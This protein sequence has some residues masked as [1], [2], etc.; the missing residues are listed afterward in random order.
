MP[1][2][3]VAVDTTLDENPPKSTK[4]SADDVLVE[5]A[6]KGD[7][8]AVRAGLEK[9]S[10]DTGSKTVVFDAVHEACRGNHD[11]CLA[12]L[13][14]YVETT[15]M[16]FGNLLS[17]CV[18]ADHVAC[19][20]VLL[21]HWKSVCSNVAMVP[22]GQEDTEGRACPA[23]WA[24]PAVCQVLIDAGADIDIYDDMGRSPLHWAC[25]SGAHAVAKILVTAGAEVCGTCNFGST[26]LIGA[27]YYGHTE[28]VRY[29]VGLKGLHDVKVNH[30]RDNLSALF[31]AVRQ[32]HTAVV[33]LLIDAGAD[34]ETTNKRLCTPLLYAC[35]KGSQP[36]V[37]MLVEAGAEVRCA[38]QDGHPCL[39]IA[40][41][42]GHIE[43]VRY[44]VGVP[45]VD[46]SHK[47]EGGYTALLAAAENC[48]KRA[49]VVEVLIDAGSDIE[50]KLGE[51]DGRSPLLVA[52]ECGNL[53]AVEVLVR[54]GADV[55]VTDNEGES[56][57]TLA[58][59]YGHTE[60]VRTLLC[61]PEVDMS[62]SNNS[63]NTSLHHAVLK[64]YSGVVQLLIDAGADV[65]ANNSWGSRPLHWA[66]EVG[67]LEIVEMLVKA[68]AD[69]C[70]VDDNSTT[71]LIV[72]ALHGRTETV[73]YL[74]GLNVDVNHRDLSGLTALHHA[75][76]KQHADVVQVLLKHGA[77]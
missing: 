43:T 57:L 11:E 53:R 1:K 71:C 65:K 8:T 73:R 66:S 46:V 69:V 75:R 44:L 59:G 40:A 4:V 37:K 36:I 34:L 33:K 68:G 30:K 17:E 2:R 12:L 42:F 50:A 60:T 18:H 5:A 77:T 55:C 27:A 20:E 21:Q 45:Q 25:R 64:K 7:M 58:A 23:M 26:C 9:L 70:V 56:C 51:R 49:D 35:E 63:G 6:K 31:D 32:K 76:Q 13:L 39:T 3:H 15:Q 52:S 14:P 41:G 28:T 10:P 24:D 47:E 48:Q 72:A 16:G 62:Q 22:H 19:T 29:L 54:A 38:P 67:E 74:L 61:V